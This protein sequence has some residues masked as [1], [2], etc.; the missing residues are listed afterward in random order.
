MS[1][2]MVEV[3]RLPEQYQY[4]SLCGHWDS[5]FKSLLRPIYFA[6]TRLLAL[7]GGAAESA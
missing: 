2:F 7:S 3:V 5:K 1:P 6:G 4:K